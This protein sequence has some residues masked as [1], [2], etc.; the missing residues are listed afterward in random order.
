MRNWVA[1]R[2]SSGVAAIVNGTRGLRIQVFFM[3][4]MGAMVQ[5][6]HKVYD[7][8]SDHRK[9]AVELVFRRSELSKE[10]RAT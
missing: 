8:P 6:H 3:A 5:R 7:Y 10:A 2:G 1:G 4:D 9:D